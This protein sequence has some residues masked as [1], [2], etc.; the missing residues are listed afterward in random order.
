M[1]LKTDKCQQS[2]NISF[3]CCAIDFSCSAAGCIS[4]QLENVSGGGLSMSQTLR[5]RNCHCF[6]S[7]VLHPTEVT[8]SFREGQHDPLVSNLWSGA[9]VLECTTKLLDCSLLFAD[10]ELFCVKLQCEPLLFR[11]TCVL[12]SKSVE[13]HVETGKLGHG[14]RKPADTL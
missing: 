8:R 14:L 7:Q 10:H 9:D 13:T 12:T 4:C 1:A 6:E 5:A 11:T 2:S 3:T